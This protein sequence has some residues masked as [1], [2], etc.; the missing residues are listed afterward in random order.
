MLKKI[1]IGVGV[2]LVALMTLG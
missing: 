2:M 1:L